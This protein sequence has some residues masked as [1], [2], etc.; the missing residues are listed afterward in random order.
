MFCSLTTNS[1]PLG[2]FTNSL[3]LT[4]SLQSNMDPNFYF[5]PVAGFPSFQCCPTQLGL[6]VSS[7]PMHLHPPV[8]TDQPDPN[9]VLIHHFPTHVH[10]EQCERKSDTPGLVSKSQ[11]FPTLNLGFLASWL[12]FFRSFQ[13]LYKI[14]ISFLGH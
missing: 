3:S 8:I 12:F 2:S 1:P 4:F 5:L 6:A 10:L 9:P 11:W 13:S 7:V 14:F